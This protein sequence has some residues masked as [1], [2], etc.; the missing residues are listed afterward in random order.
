MLSRI[1]QEILLRG[2][3]IRDFDGDGNVPIESEE[4]E[5]V[6]PSWFGGLTNEEGEVYGG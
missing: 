5:E 3:T 1:G 6:R 4:E 2:L